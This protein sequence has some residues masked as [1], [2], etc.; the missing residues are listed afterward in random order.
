MSSWRAKRNIFRILYWKLNTELAGIFEISGVTAPTV[1][2]FF[3]KEEL[4]LTTLELSI[5]PLEKVCKALVLVVPAT[6]HPVGL[7]K[8]PSMEEK[9]EKPLKSSKKT[10]PQACVQQTSASE[11]KS[12]R[13]NIIYRVL[14]LRI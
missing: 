12:K 13:F 8:E 14:I 6:F 10:C 2:T 11:K 7:E 3:G 1:S 5:P 9:E 4:F